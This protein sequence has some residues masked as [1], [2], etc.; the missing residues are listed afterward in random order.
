MDKVALVGLH[1]F[2]SLGSWSGIPC[3]IREAFEKEFSE[4]HTFEVKDSEIPFYSL[5]NKIKKSQEGLV[6]DYRRWVL[7]ARSRL[8]NNYLK[9][10]DVDCVFAVHPDAICFL[11]TDLPLAFTSDAT[12]ASILD[13]YD[14]FSGLPKETIDSGNYLWK[15]SL[16]NCNFAVFPSDWA[17]Q[18]SVNT[19]SVNS[20]KIKLI[21]YGANSNANLS[22]SEIST[23]IDDRLNNLDHIQCLFIGV[24][25]D[26]KGGDKVVELVKKLN[27]KIRTTLHIVGCE[28]DESIKSLDFV[29]HHGFLNRSIEEENVTF[30]NL[31]KRA[32]FF[33]MAPT[34]ECYGL[35]FA[36]ASSYGLPTITTNVN[37]VPSVIIEDRNGFTFKPEKYIEGSTDKILSLL[38]DAK[39]YK[40]LSQEAFNLY[41]EKLTWSSFAKEV[42]KAFIS[43]V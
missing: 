21:N 24:E 17:C 31:F 11:E 7:R 39:Y 16:D 41:H 38:E 36:E 33:T 13:F 2:Y 10:A 19:Y 4:V 40:N 28:V 9:K 35:V 23:I 25:W 26:R 14:N 29:E 27:L 15:K 30:E 22:H 32:H 8:V 6:P 5:K 37:G 3:N 1:D 18:S 34:A 42:K 20:N 12:F 43:S